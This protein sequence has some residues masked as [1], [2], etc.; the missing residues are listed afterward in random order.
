MKEKIRQFKQQL[1]CECPG[2][3]K[4]VKS[5]GRNKDSPR[6]LCERKITIALKLGQSYQQNGREIARTLEDKGW[7]KL[8]TLGVF[9]NFCP[10]CS[11]YILDMRKHNKEVWG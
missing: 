1:T 7:H 5:V 10:T 8:K 4:M 9:Q 2:Y 3:P 11:K 6:V